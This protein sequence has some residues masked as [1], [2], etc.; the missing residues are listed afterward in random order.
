MLFVAKGHGVFHRISTHKQLGQREHLASN[1]R[2]STCLIKADSTSDTFFLFFSPPC[3]LAPASP[4]GRNSQTATESGGAEAET[5]RLVPSDRSLQARRQRASCQVTSCPTP[6]VAA[7]FRISLFSSPLYFLSQSRQPFFLTQHFLSFF[8]I[9][10]SYPS[11]SAAAGA[12]QELAGVKAQLDHQLQLSN[13]YRDQVARLEA[14]ISA[15][16]STLATPTRG[17][18][19]RLASR[20]GT[21]APAQAGSA[22]ATGFVTAATVADEQEELVARLRAQIES[23]NSVIARQTLELQQLATQQIEAAEAASERELNRVSEKLRKKENELSAVQEK[24][25]LAKS[26]ESFFRQELKSERQRFAAA[27]SEIQRL[28]GRL[29]SLLATGAG[30]SISGAASSPGDSSLTGVRLHDRQT[31]N[32]WDS[33]DDSHFPSDAP[34]PLILPEHMPPTPS[35]RATSPSFFL[36]TAA[37]S[38][39]AAAANSPVPRRRRLSTE[40]DDE[41]SQLAGPSSAARLRPRF[42]SPS[43]QPSSITTA[44]ASATVPAI[45]ALTIERVRAERLQQQLAEEKAQREQLQLQLSQLQA[46]RA[47]EAAAPLSTAAAPKPRIVLPPRKSVAAAA[48]APLSNVNITAQAGLPPAA[49]V[50]NAA[51]EPSPEST[52]SSASASASKA[53]AVLPRAP[54]N[55]SEHKA[56]ALGEPAEST[57]KASAG[58]ASATPAASRAG[59]KERQQKRSGPASQ[60]PSAPTARDG[61]FTQT[62]EVPLLPDKARPVVTSTTVPADADSPASSATAAQPAPKRPRL[63]SKSQAPVAEALGSSEQAAVAL[64]AAGAAAAVAAIASSKS[65]KSAA[66]TPLPAQ[67]EA[68]SLVPKPAQRLA[69]VLGGRQSGLRAANALEELNL[70][71]IDAMLTD[72]TYP[73]SLDDVVL[74]QGSWGQQVWGRG[75]KDE[76]RVRFALSPFFS[77]LCVM[78]RHHPHSEKA[79]L[80]R[81]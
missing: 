16:R 28:Q 21:P 38:E 46:N 67:R 42:P 80:P 51:P 66:E 43:P 40:E 13:Q 1:C 76:K 14:Q 54:V 32:S 29:Q 15:L 63:Q 23:Q 64:P 7:F 72:A 17:L 39:R 77:V 59:V 37:L 44:P 27:E 20:A 62:D 34:T 52:S 61:G 57:S 2:S 58:P 8:S 3:A 35:T 31:P 81:R 12:R 24:L 56:A 9:I 4:R 6:P 33:F 48:D 25:R 30:G 5:A 49:A 68:M 53:T 18:A 36:A 19:S 26:Q 70:G 75:K 41:V 45:N 71:A 55:A 78:R 79:H 74:D 47:R 69:R 22:T 11:E 50:A 60:P 10:L 65:R 73:V